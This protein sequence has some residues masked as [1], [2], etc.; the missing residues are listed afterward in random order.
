MSFLAGGLRAGISRAVPRANALV[1]LLALAAS[2]APAVALPTRARA[3]SGRPPIGPGQ[4]P[5]AGGATQ[6]G[7]RS[8]APTGQALA[9]ALDQMTGLTPS[10]VQ[11]QDVGPAVAPGLARCAA[12]AVILDS[13]DK[14]VR[15]DVAHTRP[16]ALGPRSAQP[17]AAAAATAPAV[18]QPV[19]GT[20]A[21]LQQAYDLSYLSQAGGRGDT[22]AIV[23]AYDDPTAESDL[24]TFRNTSGLAACTT[25]NG[26]FRKVNQSG[27]A[28]PLPAGDRGW[29]EEISLDLDAVSAL[30]PN[31]HIILVEANSTMST[32]MTTAMQVAGALGAKQVSDSW[33]VS[34]S[35]PVGG[36]FTMPGVDVVAA[37]GDHGY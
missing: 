20:P 25:A 32:D 14:L 23:D 13:T 19:A 28:S 22:V 2:I 17:A 26:C 29:E 8:A 24:A 36:S 1:V 15:P 11:L 3:D 35:A 16:L 9:G 27:A 4:T 33:S 18:S 7:L 34:S 12:Q 30:C 6:A 21:Y 5:N 37:T 31:C 10:Q